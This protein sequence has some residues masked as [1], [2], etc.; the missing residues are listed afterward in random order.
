MERVLTGQAKMP[1]DK[2]NSQEFRKAIAKY[3][4]AKGIME[5]IPKSHCSLVV[6]CDSNDVKASH[7]VPRILKSE[8]LAHLYGVGEVVFE[9]PKAVW[10]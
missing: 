6:W 2:L 4:G 9:C 5:D 10:N 8:E 3:Y 7:I 1:E